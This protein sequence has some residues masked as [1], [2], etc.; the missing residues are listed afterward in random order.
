M[1]IFIRACVAA[2]AVAT[3]ILCSGCMPNNPYAAG[4]DMAMIRTGSQMFGH[5]I[6]GDGGERRENAREPCVI[7]RDGSYRDPQ[8]DEPCRPPRQQVVQ[9]EPQYQVQ[10]P[11]VRWIVPGYWTH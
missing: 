5:L 10:Q 3:A 6:G 8:T 2:I 1:E 7:Y 11:V 9:Y 4:V